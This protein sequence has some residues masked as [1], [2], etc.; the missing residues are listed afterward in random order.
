MIHTLKLQPEYF[1]LMKAGTKTIEVRLLDEKRKQIK[2]GD[3]IE[4][5]KEPEREEKLLTLVKDLYYYPTFE[6]LLNSYPIEY[7]AGKDILKEE[8]LSILNTFYSR[9]EQEEYGVVGIKVEVM[10][11]LL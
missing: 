9:E 1:K 4:F 10:K 11:V 5:I 2:V 3:E 7:F 8:F 6:E